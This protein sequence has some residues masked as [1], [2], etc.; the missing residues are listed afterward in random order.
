MTHLIK[1]SLEEGA[2]AM[3]RILCKP[4]KTRDD[5]DQLYC[6]IRAA[7]AEG[8][9]ITVEVWQECEGVYGEAQ[10]LQETVKEEATAV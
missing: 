5:L 9:A 1:L 8:E 4:I 6:V 3:D 7:I 10:A 2:S